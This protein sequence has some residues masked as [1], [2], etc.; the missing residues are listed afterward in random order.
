MHEKSTQASAAIQADPTRF[1]GLCLLRAGRFWAGIMP[2]NSSKLITAEISITT[3]LAA[4]GLVFLW[5]NRSM[6]RSLLTA[7]FFLYPLPYYLTHADIRFRL[8]LEPI[9]LMMSVY[10]VQCFIEMRKQRARLRAANS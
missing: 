9:A 10:A 5:R 3:V 2:S 6:A 4:A 7:P 1:A 8:V